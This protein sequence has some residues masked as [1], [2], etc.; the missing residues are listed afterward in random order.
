MLGAAIGIAFGA[1]QFF[2]L[3]RG[4]RSIAAQD[5]KL[6]PLIIQ[7]FCPFAG[8]LLCAFVARK[9]LLVCGICI[10][11]ILIAGAIINLLFQ[12]GKKDK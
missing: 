11:V 1:A 9:D 8:L 2:L 7:F 12:S 3:L 10:I 4:V 6:L 5:M